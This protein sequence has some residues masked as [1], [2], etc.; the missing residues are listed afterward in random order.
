[1]DFFLRIK[2]LQVQT[3]QGLSNFQLLHERVNPGRNYMPDPL[4]LWGRLTRFTYMHSTANLHS[5][6]NLD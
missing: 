4:L 5:E 6:S 2:G 1:M 3:T